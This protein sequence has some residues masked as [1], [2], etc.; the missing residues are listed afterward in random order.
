MGVRADDFFDL[1]ENVVE[2]LPFGASDIPRDE[3]AV[4]QSMA[5]GVIS[6][7]AFLT[8]SD[9]PRFKI[10]AEKLKNNK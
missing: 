6:N 10:L 7:P 8:L 2:E 4:K 9:N 1:I 5:D 3:K